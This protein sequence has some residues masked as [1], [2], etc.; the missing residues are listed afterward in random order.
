[1]IPSAAASR[2]DAAI[3]WGVLVVLATILALGAAL[4]PLPLGA[5]VLCLSFAAVTFRRYGAVEGIWYLLL[6]TLPLR[7][8]LGYDVLGTRTLYA[9]DVIL[10]LLALAALLRVGIVR[11]WKESPTL[12]IGVV[13]IL[14]STV[15]LYARSDATAI[16]AVHRMVG[17]LGA[18]FVARHLIRDGKTAQRT[19]L[20]FL[21]GMIP[22][23]LYGLHQAATPLVGASY[24]TWAKAP[25]TYDASGT[26]HMRAFSTFNHTLHFSQAL[27]MSFG[28][29]AA[30]VLE[31]H[32]AAVRCFALG[33]AVLSGICNQ[34]TYSVS[35]IVGMAVA[36][37]TAVLGQRRRWVTLLLPVLAA[38]SILFAPEAL[39]ERVRHLATGRSI[40]TVVR[41]LTYKEGLR[42]LAEHPIMGV[43]WG[44][45]PELRE[46]FVTEKSLPPA[47]ENFFLHRAVSIGL[48]GLFLFI[49]L[50]VLYLRNLRRGWRV[51]DSWPRLAVLVG[52]F[53]YFAQAMFIPGE[54]YTN[55]Y[56]LWILFAI[57]ERMAR[58]SA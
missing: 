19:I 4:A 36:A 3:A 51:G 26:P 12:R 43:G 13:I 10:H 42:T 48:P 34:F 16:V 8:P 7:E 24:P 21:A 18:F 50:V 39:F 44:G 22:A 37:V 52:G 30:L 17:Q 54:S 2:S 57:A 55:N 28:M 15:G 38:A 35:G 46:E 31:S 47:P 45:I 23:I 27:S 32:S 1:M 14:I 58:E 20:W 25:I 6:F 49:A 9:S 41:M 11:P 40:S 33:A 29:A 53:A 56:F 5:A